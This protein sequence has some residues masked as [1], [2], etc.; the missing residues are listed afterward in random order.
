M[1]EHQHETVFNNFKRNDDY[2]KNAMSGETEYE[3]KL[4]NNGLEYAMNSPEYN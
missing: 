3:S 1:Y 2:A 4:N